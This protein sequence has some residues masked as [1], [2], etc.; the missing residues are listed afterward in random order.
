MSHMEF[1]MRWIRAKLNKVMMFVLKYKKGL[2][3]I[4][5]F[6]IFFLYVFMLT[7]SIYIDINKINIKNGII[8]P[9]IMTIIFICF[10]GISV[11]VFLLNEKKYIII[12]IICLIFIIGS[13]IGTIFIY[14]TCLT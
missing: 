8:L 9:I 13:I 5:G 1:K 2:S 6:F 3:I 11:C 12:N 7:I 10:S 4:I 14:I